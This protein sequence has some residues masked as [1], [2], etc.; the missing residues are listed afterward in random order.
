MASTKHIGF[1]NNSKTFIVC[2]LGSAVSHHI[3]QLFLEGSMR[4][5]EASTVNLA[6]DLVLLIL[7]F[8]GNS[9]DKYILFVKKNMGLCKTKT[10][11]EKDNGTLFFFF[12]L[13]VFL[14]LVFCRLS[15]RWI[16]GGVLQSPLEK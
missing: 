11:M 16:N 9:K 4:K 13:V 10:G 3:S 12:F 14:S 1:G 15:S 5:T 8:G 2:I 6:H 7:S